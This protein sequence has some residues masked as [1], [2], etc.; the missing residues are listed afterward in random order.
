MP[1]V[2]FHSLA[3]KVFVNREEVRDL[4][5][6][7]RID[8]RIVPHVRISR[9][10]L[11]DGQHLLIE[12]TLVEHL[13]QADRPHLHHAAWKA[14]RIHQHQ[15]VERIAVVAQCRRNES[16]VSRVVHRRVEIPIQT[17]D[18]QLLVVFILVDALKRNL[19]D[20]VYNFGHLVA[21]RQ[22]QIIDHVNSSVRNLMRNW[23]NTSQWH[24]RLLAPNGTYRCSR[25][26]L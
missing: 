2:D 5:Q 22:L 15:H 12:N 9:I 3:F 4:L 16:I 7:V 25:S 24:R 10:I 18:V 19:D 14:G 23:R 21:N 17:K 8:L 1:A 26:P 13:H 11:A 20:G 6:H